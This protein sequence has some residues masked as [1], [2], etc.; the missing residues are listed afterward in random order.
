M[1]DTMRREGDSIPVMFPK[2]RMV[3][4]FDRLVQLPT[5]RVRPQPIEGDPEARSYHT[6]DLPS[7][8]RGRSVFRPDL[9]DEEFF[10]LGP[11][12]R[13]RVALLSG[14]PVLRASES[15]ADVAKFEKQ[16]Q[17]FEKGILTQQPEKRRVR[18]HYSDYRLV[19]SKIELRSEEG[20]RH[21]GVILWQ[22]PSPSL[23]STKI[24][25]PGW[26]KVEIKTK[27]RMASMEAGQVQNVLAKFSKNLGDELRRVPRLYPVLV[28]KPINPL[29][30]KFSDISENMH[31]EQMMLR[32]LQQIQ[33]LP[34]IQLEDR[35]YYTDLEIQRR[36]REE[37]LRAEQEDKDKVIVVRD[38]LYQDEP[39]WDSSDLVMTQGAVALLVSDS[40]EE[41]DGLPKQTAAQ[42]LGVNRIPDVIVARNLPRVLP[43]GAVLKTGTYSTIVRM[44]I[45][46]LHPATNVSEIPPFVPE[47]EIEYDDSGREILKWPV[48]EKLRAQSDSELKPPLAIRIQ[49]DQ[50]LVVLAPG[51]N[52][53]EMPPFWDRGY[54][55]TTQ[56][57][58]RL[59]NGCHMVP[60][61]SQQVCW[62][63][64]QR[65]Q[66]KDLLNLLRGR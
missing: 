26:E 21:Y 54:E 49:Q 59:P 6:I 32:L 24:K 11:E 27:T 60:F 1:I 19:A 44:T 12:E 18:K 15:P 34:P 16:Q 40:V 46:D 42:V 65:I 23:T 52:A 7:P 10:S 36:E 4:R 20:T 8:L 53:C 39:D 55:R 41:L 25:M 28:T 5:M 50:T 61:G 57:V 3:G 37:E 64:S 56:K 35:V 51:Q 14:A 29:S 17:L 30:H 47:P 63:T 38:N 2:E 48:D 33:P 66:P 9:T 13:L 31:E 22:C 45:D 62:P 58:L 43:G